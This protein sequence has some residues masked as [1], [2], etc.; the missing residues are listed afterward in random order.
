MPRPDSATD[1]QR[2]AL[3]RGLALRLHR[4]SLDEARVVD[5]VLAR[6][7]IGRE[8]YGELDLAKPRDWRRERFE[9]RLDA[10]VYD[11]CEELAA[12]DTVNNDS[13]PRVT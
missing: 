9:E 3:A 12:E 13:N 6:L 7:E 1:I 5:R 11:V 4:C 8:R 2:Q 10:L